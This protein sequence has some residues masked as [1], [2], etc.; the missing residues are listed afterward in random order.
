MT[1]SDSFMQF[2]KCK[3]MKDTNFFFADDVRGTNRAIQYCQD[4]VVKTQCAQYA[5]D[6][7]I[8]HGV[9]GGLSMRARSRMKKLQRINQ[10]A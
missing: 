5:I 9:W 10:N 3:T 4:C 1:T 7:K 8:N 6:N 2:A